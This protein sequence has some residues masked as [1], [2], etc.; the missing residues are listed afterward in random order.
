MSEGR[1]GE[2]TLYSRLFSG[3]L[4]VWWGFFSYFQFHKR[5]WSGNHGSRE[6]VPVSSVK[7]WV[8]GGFFVFV[9]LFVVPLPGGRGAQKWSQASA[10]EGTQKWIS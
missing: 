1:E 4:V 2:L 3:K 10:G 5:S 9:F 7:G 8:L 6:F